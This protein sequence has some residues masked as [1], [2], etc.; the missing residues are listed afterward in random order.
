VQE[1]LLARTELLLAGD[2]VFSARDLEDLDIIP[3]DKDESHESFMVLVSIK[4]YPFT[5]PQPLRF[6]KF[7]YAV[8][9]GFVTTEIQDKLFSLLGMIEELR[10]VP[11]Y[12]LS[13]KENFTRFAAAVAEQL[14][15]VDFLSLWAAN[16]DPIVPNTASEFLGFPSWVP[17]WTWVPFQAPFRLAVGGARTKT[18]ED[19]LWNAAKGRKHV[20]DQ[21][22]DAAKTRHLWVRGRV[23]D[24]VDTVSSAR[25]HR[26]WDADDE[27]LFGLLNQI[28]TDL[29]GLE[30]WVLSDM[31]RVLQAA[32]WN[33]K[34]PEEPAKEVLQMKENVIRDAMVEFAGVNERLGL[35][36][37]MGRGRRFMKTENGRIGLAPA[38]GSRARQGDIKGSLIVVLHG[39]IVPIMLE[40]VDQER[41]KYKV[42][43]DCYVEG[44]MHG[45]AVTWE[46]QDTETFILV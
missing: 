27:Y 12:S 22:E 18:R 20:H 2:C 4:R 33:G 3:Q 32:S 11:N 21:P 43:G 16:L 41:K 7:M 38:V 30:H 40:P 6:L 44:I 29:P 31:I 15:S 24:A 8:D 35:C 39:C 26:Y 36:L 10:F 1:Y 13:I 28:K 17:S 37:A 19:V 34:E 25:F 45:D 23:V 9:S 42:V 14:C 5:D 46:E